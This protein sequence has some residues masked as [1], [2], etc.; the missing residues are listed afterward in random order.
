MESG[1]HRGVP[2]INKLQKKCH[3]YSLVS[4]H[5]ASIF[6]FHFSSS[7]SSQ[8]KHSPQTFIVFLTLLYSEKVLHFC[9]VSSPFFASSPS[10]SSSFLFC[11]WLC[12]NSIRMV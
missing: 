9:F 3:I 2:E 7:S 8:S 10:S 6:C 11:C 4:E 1:V 5:E 12:I